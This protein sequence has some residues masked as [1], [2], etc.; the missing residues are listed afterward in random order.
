MLSKNGFCF[1]MR[2]LPQVRKLTKFRELAIGYMGPIP[3]GV[4]SKVNFE[5][6]VRFFY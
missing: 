2:K 4:F 1:Y 3:N 5:K 6:C